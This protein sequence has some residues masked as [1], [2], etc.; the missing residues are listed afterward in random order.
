MS[1]EKI[2]KHFGLVT[3]LFNFRMTAFSVVKSG[4]SAGSSVQHRFIR[5]P[6][7]SSEVKS[8]ILGL[9]HISLFFTLSTISAK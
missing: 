7:S 8:V 5:T 3:Y 1:E 2:C 6:T 9:R 4:R